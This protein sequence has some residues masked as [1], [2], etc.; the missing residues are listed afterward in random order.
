[1]A[2]DAAYN[3]ATHLLAAKLNLSAG[4][5]N[6]TAEELEDAGIAKYGDGFYEDIN[7]LLA[8]ADA[9]LNSVECIV[10]KKTTIVGFDG[11]GSCLGPK[12]KK[13]VDLRAEA[14]YLASLLDSYNN[15]E[16]CTGDPT[17]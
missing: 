8:D 16:V 7:D 14:F 2:N 11:E 6:P 3:L 1:M 5:C 13:D 12:N 15:A 17:H 10:D 9:L 4:A